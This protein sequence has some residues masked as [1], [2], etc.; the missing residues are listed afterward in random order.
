M[1]YILVFFIT[2][3]FF[4]NAYSQVGFQASEECHENIAAPANFEHEERKEVIDAVFSYL[5]VGGGLCSG[6]LINRNIDDGSLGYYFVTAWHCLDE[7]DFDAVHQLYFN[8]QSNTENEGLM[9]LTNRGE[10]FNQSNLN[11]FPSVQDGYEYLHRTRLR[12]VEQSSAYLGDFALVEILTPLPPHFNFTYAGWAPSRFSAGFPVSLWSL[13]EPIP[14]KNVMVHHPV[15]D[16]KKV[17]GFNNFA[18]MENPA[19][20]TCYAVTSVIDAI[21][22][23]F[24]GGNA[25]NTSSICRFVDYPWMHIPRWTYGVSE[26]GSSGA[27]VFNPFNEL[28]GTNKGQLF[29]DDF[30]DAVQDAG[31]GDLRELALEF[32]DNPDNFGGDEALQLAANLLVR[33]FP[34]IFFQATVEGVCD[35]PVMGSVGKF[36][37][38]YQNNTVRNTLNPTGDIWVDINGMPSRKIDCYEQLQLPGAAG[39]SGQ[40]FP[41]KHYQ[42]ENKVVLHAQNEIETDE[43]NPINVYSGAEYELKGSS[44]KLT[45][46]FRIENGA[47]VLMKIES[48][49]IDKRREL[50][51]KEKAKQRSL[52][53][54]VPQYKEFD[55]SRYADISDKAKKNQFIESSRLKIYPNPSNGNFTLEL[56]NFSN[57]ST[58]TI[59]KIV[60]V[61][62]QVVY[63]ETIQSTRTM[64]HVETLANGIY[65]L[66]LNTNGE[67]YT[68]KIVINQ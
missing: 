37:W 46:G 62:G 6:T 56:E 58:G 59:L 7:T 34:G 64:L 17:A 32:I 48:C 54:H 15:G 4:K 45:S 51:P 55:M 29:R 24:T 5:S 60:N 30:I 63:T 33:T 67:V 36:H 50:T 9:P 49:D 11:T 43:N 57:E 12:L 18:Y 35:F 25:I 14:T 2:I 20:T 39:V 44:I 68:Q 10:T 23:L 47:R 28:I 26:G 16:I 21:S 22:T 38:N 27:G 3:L 42:D 19:A 53:I 8:F 40:Y 65:Y 41:A 13:I 1:K 61:I 52:A 31:A 66:H